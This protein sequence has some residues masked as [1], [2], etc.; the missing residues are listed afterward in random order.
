MNDE[1]QDNGLGMI[2]KVLALALVCAGLGF[3]AVAVMG[4]PVMRVAV[5]VGVV[6][7]LVVNA[8]RMAEIKRI[9]N[10]VMEE[11]LEQEEREH[12]RLR[13]ILGEE[14]K[15]ELEEAHKERKIDEKLAEM[16]RRQRELEEM[17]R[18]IMAMTGATGR[19]GGERGATG[20]APQDADG[21]GEGATGRALQD[22][23]GDGAEAAWERV[24]EMERK[25]GFAPDEAYLAALHTAAAEGVVDA[26]ARLGEVALG[27]G[28]VVEA[29]YWTLLADMYGHPEVATTL[30]N[31]RSHWMRTGCPDEAENVSE[32][33]S[34]M[35]GDFAR[36]VL[37]V[38]SGINA[39]LARRQLEG[40]AAAGC[41]EAQILL[42]R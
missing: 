26:M 4:F 28:T 18:R 31:L 17:E 15:S 1:A 14:E 9:Q 29:F 23:D 24:L 12:E 19:G 34:E 6:F 27:R 39:P 25:A 33:F 40:L 10:A 2:F 32:T 22:A 3:A 42:E 5:V 35:Q 41:R 36:A 7:V 13:A 21:Y 8:V 11:K 38:Q 16:A 30:R 20:R 37:A